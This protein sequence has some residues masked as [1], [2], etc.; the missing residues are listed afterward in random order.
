MTPRS[1]SCRACALL[2]SALFVTGCASQSVLIR[3]DQLPE[4]AAWTA[5][6]PWPRQPGSFIDAYGNNVELRGELKEV[7]VE[8]RDMPEVKESYEA[9]VKAAI[10]GNAMFVG[11]KNYNQVYLPRQISSVE[12][13]VSDKYKNMRTA[14]GVLLG[15]G[16]GF[17]G[18]GLATTFYLLDKGGLGV[19][20]ALLIGPPLGAAGI[21]CL[22]TG[23]IFLATEYPPSHADDKNHAKAVPQLRVGPGNAELDWTF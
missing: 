15:V 3:P 1:L 14:G 4:V 19:L 2:A 10:R 20:G 12:V 7:V 9:P 6:K 13:H 21:A 18:A 22:T 17:M 8:R 23:G 16:G 11:G 5:E